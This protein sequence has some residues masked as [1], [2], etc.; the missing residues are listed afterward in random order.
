MK[1]NLQTGQIYRILIISRL[2][3][4]SPAVTPG[5]NICLEVDYQ[6]DSLEVFVPFKTAGLFIHALL[7]ILECYWMNQDLHPWKWAM[8]LV[9]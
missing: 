6:G 9:G 7:Q 4:L 1:I 2:L 8:N 5:T 3:N